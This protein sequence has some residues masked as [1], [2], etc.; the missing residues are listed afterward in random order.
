MFPGTQ[1]KMT[2]GIT[3]PVSLTQWHSF[4]CC[5]VFECR[6]SSVH[7]P[8]KIRWMHNT[9]EELWVILSIYWCGKCALWYVFP[10]FGVFPTCSKWIKSLPHHFWCLPTCNSIYEAKH[11]FSSPEGKASSSLRNNEIYTHAAVKQD[12]TFNLCLL[13]TTNQTEVMFANNN[14]TLYFRTFE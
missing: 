13:E 14:V 2:R 5:A 8:D 6:K 10:K 7:L 1:H 4:V 9:S 12:K 11:Q 3:P